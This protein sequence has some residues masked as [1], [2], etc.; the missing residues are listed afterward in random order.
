MNNKRF[1]VVGATGMV[2]HEM[3]AVLSEH[4]VP[5]ANVVPVASEKSAGQFVKYGNTQLAVSTLDSVDFHVFDIALFSAGSEVSAV[6]APIAANA[7][8]VVIDNSSY[9]RGHDDV[10]LIVPEV[11]M[12]DISKYSNKRLIANPNCSTIQVVMVLKPLHDMFGLRELVMSTYQ[13]TS[14]AGQ[15][16]V[17]ELLEQISTLKAGR[18]VC[19]QY[20]RKQIAFNAIPQIDNFSELGYTREELKMMNETRKILGV[21][22]IITTAT[23]VRIPVV[24]GHAVSVFAKFAEDID[25]HRTIIA[26]NEFPGVKVVDDN[27]TYTYATPIDAAGGNDVLVSRMRRHPNLKNALSFWCVSDNLRKGAALNAVQIASRL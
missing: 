10:A 15:K 5:Y 11:N 3:L 24:T 8:C 6:Y 18:V 2:G 27:A 22:D 23:C 14:G 1:V 25:I 4:H 12:T 19:T 21:G 9:F 7:G 16:A 13:A 17:N 26:L 20:F